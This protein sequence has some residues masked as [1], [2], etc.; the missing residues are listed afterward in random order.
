MWTM[1]EGD[2]VPLMGIVLVL[3]V[4]Y[5]SVHALVR[6]TLHIYYMNID[7]RVSTYHVNVHYTYRTLYDHIQMNVNID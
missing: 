3:M 5:G 4:I 1:A 2:Y 7:Y 6:L